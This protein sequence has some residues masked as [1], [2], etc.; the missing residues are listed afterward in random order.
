MR[1]TLSKKPRLIPSFRICDSLSG[2]LELAYTGVGGLIVKFPR[3]LQASSY[4]IGNLI[5]AT[6]D[7]LHRKDQQTLQIRDLFLDSL[8]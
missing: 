3:I 8:K 6:I 5:S 1:E 4:T 7:V 2:V